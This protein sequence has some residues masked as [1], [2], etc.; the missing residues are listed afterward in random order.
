MTKS[1]NKI[2]LMVLLLLQALSS[3]AKSKLVLRL[4]L[5]GNLHR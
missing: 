4:I 1:Y 2:M 5:L 3:Y